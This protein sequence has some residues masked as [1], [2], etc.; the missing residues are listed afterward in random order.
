MQEK[1]VQKAL[2]T[3][4]RMTETSKMQVLEPNQLGMKFVV[5]VTDQE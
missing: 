3:V 5:V 1:E 2:E 4:L